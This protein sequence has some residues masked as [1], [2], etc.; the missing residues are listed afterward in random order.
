MNNETGSYSLVKIEISINT[1]RKWDYVSSVVLNEKTREIDVL[2][3]SEHEK[4][5]KKFYRESEIDME[6]LQALADAEE[7]TIFART[8]NKN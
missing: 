8:Y 2:E 3:V 7:L 5:A 4:D 6:L 1:Q